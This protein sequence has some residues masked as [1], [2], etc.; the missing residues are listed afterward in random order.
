MP[1]YEPVYE[2]KICPICNEFYTVNVIIKRER[3]R[4]TCGNRS[5]STKLGALNSQ[6]I[7]VRCKI[8]ETNFLLSK[9]N[10]Q[11]DGNYCS[12]M[13][14]KQRYELECKNC[15]SSFRA[16]RT[17]TNYC[18][19]NCELEGNRN[20][21]RTSICACCN[22]EFSRPSHTLPSNKR[23]FCSNRCAQR[24]F[25]RENPNRY[26]NNWYRIREKKV[27]QDNYTCNECHEQKLGKYELHVHHVIPI[28]EFDNIDDAHYNDN[29]E[30]LC[31]EC[32]MEHHNKEILVDSWGDG[33]TYS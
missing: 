23:H 25:S 3:E 33:S 14:R 16:D 13:C 27:R 6:K 29:L 21:L 31:Y 32:H 26:G 17:T 11:K 24:Q 19:S 20:N 22:L 5:C 15:N 28:E 8:C 2:N 7:N 18:S 1:R 12:D 30:T 9:H 10:I 4:K